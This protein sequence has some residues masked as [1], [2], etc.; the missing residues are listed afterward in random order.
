[1]LARA[2][3]AEHAIME[4]VDDDAET[5]QFTLH[6][7]TRRIATAVL[8]DLRMH[9]VS[10]VESDGRHLGASASR[11]DA[12]CGVSTRRAGMAARAART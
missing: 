4:K 11:V 5:R 7:R 3:G 1:M 9:K 6:I 8:F 12:R 10:S 2:L